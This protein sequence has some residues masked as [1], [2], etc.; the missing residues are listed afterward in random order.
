MGHPDRER[1]AEAAALRIQGRTYTQIAEAL[2]YNDRSAAYKAAER[3]FERSNV[4]MKSEVK[5]L[6][7]A[8]IEM[9]LTGGSDNPGGMLG[10][11]AAGDVDAA[12]MCDALMRRQLALYGDGTYFRT[13]AQREPYPAPSASESLLA[14]FGIDSEED[15]GMRPGR[16][17]PPAGAFDDED[18]D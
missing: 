10:M 17:S 14:S 11:A 3:H 4:V 18:E 7:A 6:T 15:G 2:G 5:D 1:D 16:Q 12:K 8:R 13:A 9:I